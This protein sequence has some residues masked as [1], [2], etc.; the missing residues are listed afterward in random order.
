MQVLDTGAADAHE[1]LFRT[2]LNEH[3]TFFRRQ[4]QNGYDFQVSSAATLTLLQ[5]PEQPGGG[6]YKQE[7]TGER[8]EHV[9][10]LAGPGRIHWPTETA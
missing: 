8:A 6:E 3:H 7:H 10:R 9:E 2:R 1:N 4:R 5:S